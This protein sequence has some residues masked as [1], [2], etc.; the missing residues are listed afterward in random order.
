M[1]TSHPRARRR[2]T[3]VRLVAT[4][5]AALLAVGVTACSTS[6]TSTPPD[7]LATWNA[8]VADRAEAP[9]KWVALGDSITEGQGASTRSARWTDLTRDELR[10]LHPTDG[11]T[12]GV[13]YLPANFAVYAPDSTWADWAVDGSGTTYA[14][15]TVPDLGYRALAMQPGA[16][17]T[18]PF[19]GTGLDIWWARSPD[20]GDFTYRIDGGEPQTVRTTGSETT[21]AVT[22]VDGLTRGEHTV[23]V[24]AVA[25]F[26]LEGF[27]IYDGD[28]DAGIHLYD[29]ARSG[30]TIGTFTKDEAGFLRAM[31][32]V[33]PDL[34]TITLGGNDA[35][36]I[37]PDE[38]GRQYRAFLRALRSLPSKPSLL[39]IGEFTPAPAMTDGMS[40]SWSTYLDAIERAAKSSGAAWVSMAD[41][42]PTA[43]YAGTGI[44]STD[45][46]HPND[47]GQRKI[48]KLVLDTLAKHD[49]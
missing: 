48:A 40:A 46:L 33:G 37:T 47:R 41:T 15:D 17:R 45:G 44:Y 22:R 18:W 12:G 1:H 30:A 10:R 36:H 26:A 5:L 11:T 3:T 4:A 20:S 16:T 32:R 2:R 34:I 38:L 24:T 9:A 7:P 29:S 35:G 42:F 19:T 21:G 8:A 25:T 27:T 14:I 43:T 23:T 39:V 13:G 28:R 49:G 6:S 31:R